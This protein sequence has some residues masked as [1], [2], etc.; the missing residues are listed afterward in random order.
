VQGDACHP[1]EQGGGQEKNNWKNGGR[2]GETIWV[3]DQKHF[4][5]ITN[6]MYIMSKL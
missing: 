2:V 5:F 3:T 6:K 1:E 4:F